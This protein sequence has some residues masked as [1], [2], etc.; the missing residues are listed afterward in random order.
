MDIE[1]P[2]IGW[3]THLPPDRHPVPFV[4]ANTHAGDLVTLHLP[5]VSTLEGMV[6]IDPDQSSPSKGSD[7]RQVVDE[8]AWWVPKL[9]PNVPR[10]GMQWTPTEQ[11]WVYQDAV[12]DQSSVPEGPQ[13]AAPAPH[14][15]SHVEEGL[16]EPPVRRPRP[17][18]EHLPLTGKVVRVQ[19]GRGNWEWWRAASEA[20]IDK[21]GDIVVNICSVE[22]YWLSRI[23][24]ALIEVY[25]A[26]IH[27]L[28][29]YA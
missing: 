15:L 27:R 24:N 19:R 18:R 13:E 11:I 10:S 22:K 6:L 20:Y 21:D 29:V 1:L 28:F 16:Q 23:N 25:P 4:Y 8:F 2:K 5:G 7:C 26:P 12:S 14:W 3:S 9:M 17:A